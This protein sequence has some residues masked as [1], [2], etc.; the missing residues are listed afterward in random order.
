MFASHLHAGGLEEIARSQSSALAYNP[1][2]EPSCHA[3]HLASLETNAVTRHAFETLT[4]CYLG[5]TVTL[6][7]GSPQ[8]TLG[9]R[10]HADAAKL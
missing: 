2:G 4:C 7:T 3:R 6:E 9:L 8:V 5:V 1:L 10:G